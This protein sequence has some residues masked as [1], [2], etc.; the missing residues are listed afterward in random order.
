M[1]EREV[2]GSGDDFEIEIR[3]INVVDLNS[4]T[5]RAMPSPANPAKVGFSPN[6][7]STNE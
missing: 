2:E 5:I 7:I 1:A 4:G 3:C 6:S